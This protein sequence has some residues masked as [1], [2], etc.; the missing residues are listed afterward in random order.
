MLLI[1]LHIP[2]DIQPKLQKKKKKKKNTKNAT[3][4]KCK[5]HSIC[6]QI[7]FQINV[8]VQIQTSQHDMC[9]EQEISEMLTYHFIVQSSISQQ[10]KCNPKRTGFIASIFVELAGAISK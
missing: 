10:M 1:I 5:K 6:L 8:C 9:W 7:R 3:L 2:H 4:Q